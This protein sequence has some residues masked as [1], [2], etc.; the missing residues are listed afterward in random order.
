MT[1]SSYQHQDSSG[2]VTTFSQAET[3]KLLQDQGLTAAPDLMGTPNDPK[4]KQDN[5]Q[6]GE[7]A[8]SFKQG[9]AL[10]QFG[11]IHSA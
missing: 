5:K 3:T 6:S 1:S 8:E 4:A 9:L 11:T 2:S 10:L 7:S